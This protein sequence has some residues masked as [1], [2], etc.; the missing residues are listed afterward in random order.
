MFIVNDL[1]WVLSTWHRTNSP[2]CLKTP[3]SVRIPKLQLQRRIWPSEPFVAYGLQGQTSLLPCSRWLLKTLESALRPLPPFGL[4]LRYTE[5]HSCAYWFLTAAVC[6]DQLETNTG[7]KK[8]PN[9]A[10]WPF[11]ISD[12]F[13]TRDFSPFSKWRLRIITGKYLN[14]K[15]LLLLG[16]SSPKA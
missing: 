8:G 11:L 7:N 5:S 10:V 15:W 12:P 13:L 4:G 16:E 3:E 2:Q 14:F 6:T 1:W 9:L